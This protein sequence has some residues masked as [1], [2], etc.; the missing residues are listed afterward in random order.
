MW[1]CQHGTDYWVYSNISIQAYC[2]GCE[3]VTNTKHET[4]KDKDKNS[5]PGKMVECCNWNLNTMF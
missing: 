1:T 2:G 4:P 3:D 5:C